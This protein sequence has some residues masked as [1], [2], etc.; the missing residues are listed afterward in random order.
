MRYAAMQSLGDPYASS[1]RGMGTAN[2][3]E[4]VVIVVELAI[5]AWLLVGATGLVRTVRSLRDA[6]VR[7]S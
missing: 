1:M 7:Q 4:L 6:G 5:G 3:F 2:L